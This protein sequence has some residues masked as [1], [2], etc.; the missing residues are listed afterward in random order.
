M[1]S[2]TWT[3]IVLAAVIGL[4]LSS[5]LR[6]DLL[7]AWWHERWRGASGLGAGPALA[8]RHHRTAGHAPHPTVPRRVALH[9]RRP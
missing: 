2:Q 5:V 9:R 7:A 8:G 6:F 4:A 3:W 1:T